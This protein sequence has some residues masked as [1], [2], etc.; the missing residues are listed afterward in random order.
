MK[1]FRN[2]YSDRD[3]LTI[4]FHGIGIGMSASVNEPLLCQLTG[5]RRCPR[6][7]RWGCGI[8]PTHR[9]SPHTPSSLSCHGGVRTHWTSTWIHP[10]D[11]MVNRYHL[12]STLLSYMT[13]YQHPHKL[14]NGFYCNSHW[15]LYWRVKL[16]FI[17]SVNQKC[18]IFFCEKWNYSG[19]KWILV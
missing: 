12:R 11:S 19:L 5:W 14:D 4:E 15:R 17:L 16:F 18:V 7:D 10:L 8:D 9:L 2:V 6:V 3:P 1:L 13:N